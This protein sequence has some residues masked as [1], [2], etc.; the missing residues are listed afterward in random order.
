MRFGADVIA[1]RGR[2]STALLWAV[3]GRWLYGM[4]GMHGTHVTLALPRDTMSLA[5][6]RTDADLV[7]PRDIAALTLP[8]ADTDL[9]L[10]R[11]A[12]EVDYP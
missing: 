2:T 1:T 5:L 11:D 12:L 3:A 6:P 7:L 10:P 9:L 4:H 8:R